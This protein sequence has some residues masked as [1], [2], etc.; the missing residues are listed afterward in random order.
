MDQQDSGQAEDKPSNQQV[1][2]EPEHGASGSKH[3]K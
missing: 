2:Q 1:K 3:V